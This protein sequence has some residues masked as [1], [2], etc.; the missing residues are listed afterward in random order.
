[1]FLFNTPKGVARVAQWKWII[2]GTIAAASTTALLAG[3]G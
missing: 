1:M 3:A 2:V